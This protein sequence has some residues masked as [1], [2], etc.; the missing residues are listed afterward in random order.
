MAM[1]MFLINTHRVLGNAPYPV[2]THNNCVSRIETKI[3]SS[4]IIQRQFYTETL[5]IWP[6]IKRK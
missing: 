3:I 1:K 2:E 5:D 4:T 6:I